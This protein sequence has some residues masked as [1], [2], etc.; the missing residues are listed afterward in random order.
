MRKNRKFYV[1]LTVLCAGALFFI[2]LLSAPPAVSAAKPV[3]GAPVSTATAGKT[4]PTEKTTAAPAV[5]AATADDKAALKEQSF[6][7][8]HTDGKTKS[9]ISCREFLVFTLAAEML[10]SF[11]PEA[12][13][14]QAVAAYT[15]FCYERDREKENPQKALCG[16]DFADTPVPYPDGYTPAYWKKKWGEDTYATCRKKLEAAVDAV[17]GIQITYEG[18]PILAAYHAISPGKTE[19]AEVAWSAAYPYLQSVDSEADKNAPDYTTTVRLTTDQLQKALADLD[20]ADFSASPKDWISP[21]VTR[22]AAGTVLKLTVGGVALSGK[23]CRTRFGL[24]SAC[25]SVAYEN[26]GFT[27]TVTG[28]GHGVGLSQYGAQFAALDGASFADILHRY[29]TD[30]TLESHKFFL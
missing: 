21:T 7:V 12:L 1:L 14:A 26:G 5:P 27:F 9:A 4:N 24:R 15:Y 8:L 2:P 30:V 10:P 20:G 28:N 16:A 22:S 25:F 13:K 18:K 23:E 29:Y 3:T 17:A 19:V 11:E 6:T